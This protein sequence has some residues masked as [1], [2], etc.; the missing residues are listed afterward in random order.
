MLKG[1]QRIIPSDLRPVCDELLNSSVLDLS[2]HELF[3][4]IFKDYF[5][6]GRTHQVVADFRGYSVKQIERILPKLLFR[7][8]ILALR[9]I[10]HHKRYL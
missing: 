10:Q 8:F 2:H 9:T 1:G 6:L 3:V 5:Y 4:N 7:L